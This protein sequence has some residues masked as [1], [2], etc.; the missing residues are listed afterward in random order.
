MDILCII[1]IDYQMTLVEVSAYH[2][3]VTGTEQYT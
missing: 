1:R 2:L 3:V